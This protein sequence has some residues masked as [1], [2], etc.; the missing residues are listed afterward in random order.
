MIDFS[1]VIGALELLSS[2]Y[3]PWLVVFPGLLIGLIA[4]ATPGF[5]VSMAMAIVLPFTFSLDF[6]SSILFLT[7]IF[8]GGG[9]GASIPCHLNEHSW[10]VLSSSFGI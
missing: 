3:T 9:Y 5:Q 10:V 7:A 4:G 8:T 6:L 2:S 1:G